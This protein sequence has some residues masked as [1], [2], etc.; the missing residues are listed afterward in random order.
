MAAM[1]IGSAIFSDAQVAGIERRIQVF[2]SLQNVQLNTILEDGR[3]QVDEA[4][5]ILATHQSGFATHETELHRNATRVNN[6]VEE[7]N[8]KEAQLNQLTKGVTEFA[9][10]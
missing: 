4:R 5:S 10:Q 9:A 7:L 3:R 1:A 2:G 6:L 8:A